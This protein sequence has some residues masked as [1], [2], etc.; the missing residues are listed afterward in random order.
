MRCSVPLM[1]TLFFVSYAQEGVV[2]PKVLRHQA[3]TGINEHA[4]QSTSVQ[5]KSG[6]SSAGTKI[7]TVAQGMV[8]RVSER[9]DESS[10]QLPPWKEVRIGN[11]FGFEKA[12]V[13]GDKVTVIPLEVNIA[14][15]ELKIVRT[16]KRQDENLPVWW[17][18]ELEPVKHKEFYEAKPVNGSRSAEAPFD[19]CIVYPVIKS[20]RAIRQDRLTKAMLPRGVTVKTVYAAIDI[21]NDRRPDALITKFC[22]Q[23]PTRSPKQQDCDYT[24]GKTYM[25][26]NDVWKLSGSSSPA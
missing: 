23:N 8:Y 19:V 5:Y 17:E 25:K 16:K 2:T 7:T 12:P 24:C 18:V 15:I 9:T 3:S 13:I 4:A 21:T 26:V 10:R 6:G 20:A 14:L 11:V 22:C 1:I